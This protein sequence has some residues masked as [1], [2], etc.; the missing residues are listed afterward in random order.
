MHRPMPMIVLGG[1]DARSGAV[2][3]DMS[4]DQMLGGFK[5]AR[6]L[7]WGRC[8]AAELIERIRG[9]DRFEAPLLVGPRRIYQDLVDVD[10][11][12]VEGNLASTLQETIEAIHRRFDMDAPVA[13]TSCDILP[14]AEEFCL[15]LDGAYLPHQDSLFWGQLVAAPR[16]AMG[17][18]AWK[19]SYQFR[20]DADHPQQNMYPG[21]LV[22]ARPNALRL[23]L[24]VQ[25]LRLAYRHRNRQL[26]QRHFRLAMG[27][28]WRL[29]QED[30][31]NLLAFQLPTMTVSIMYHG[32]SAYAKYRRGKATVADFER[33]VGRAFLHRKYH[34]QAHD[35][36][37]VFSVS[38]LVSFAKDIDTVGEFEEAAACGPGGC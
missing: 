6:P 4:A 27:G 7:P 22:I 3:R 19:P 9:T 31:R 35:R 21:H 13:I 25:L 38:P 16:E 10:I 15:L 20:P 11:V 37:V 26:R 30:L 14:T 17:V 12:D 32:L 2:P 33:A 5:G 8:M 36:P 1:S 29:I 23:T 34:H 18:S 28:L 24:T